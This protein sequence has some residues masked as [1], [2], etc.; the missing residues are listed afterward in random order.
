MKSNLIKILSFGACA[1]AACAPTSTDPQS[2]K[3]EQLIAQMTI[4]EKLGQM[5]LISDPYV[6]TGATVEVDPATKDLDELVRTGKVGNFLN[7]TG[8]AAT[9]RLQK[10]AVEESRLGIPLLFGFDVI[11]GYKT[12]FPIPLADAAS[13][14]MEAV[15]LSA[16][17]STIEAAANG[18]NWTYAP[19]VDISLDP[20]WGRVMEGAGEDVYLT[21]QV[22]LARIKGIQGSSLEDENTIAACAKHFVGYGAAEGGRDYATIELSERT[23]RNVYFPPFK[24]AADAGVASFMSAFN[25]V[26]GVPAS[27]NKWLLTDVLRG[28]WGY[29]GFMVSD[30]DSVQETIAHGT[31]S[32]DKH[33]ALNGIRAGV[34]M[35]MASEVYINHG[36]ELLAEGKINEEQLDEAVRRVLKIKFDLGLFDD[37]YKYSNVDREQSQT[38]TKEAHDASRD[39]ARKSIVLLKNEKNTLPISKSI[40]RIAVIGPLADDKDA[41]LGNWRGHATSNTAVSLLEGVRAAVGRDVEVV[42]AQG[43]RLVNNDDMHFFTPLEINTSDRSGFAEAVRVAKSAD[44]VIMAVGETAFMSGECRSYTDIELK[45]LQVELMGEIEK[46]GK[47]TVMALFT[48]RPLVLTEVVDMPEAILNCWL[49]GSEAGHAIAD[50]LFGDYNPSAKLPMTFPYHAGQVPIY[51]SQLNGGR[52]Y[53]PEQWGFSSKYRDAPNTPLYAF[54][55]GLSYTTFDYSNLALSSSQISMNGELRVSFD[56][57]NSGVFD[58][59]EVV[60]LYVRDMLGNQVSRPLLELKRFEKRELKRG[61]SAKFEF[62]ITAE[63]L[64]FW[65]IDNKFAAE[66]GEFTIFV[67]SSSDNLPLNARFTLTN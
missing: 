57:K 11:H 62:T 2:Q 5:N 36:A 63:D 64:A 35:D 50:V 55:Y 43:C 49:L 32:D 25:T 56:V 41:A 66:A 45:G 12:M 33:A 22:G 24:A 19:M 16:Y 54:G 48:G 46:V 44:V 20:R 61:E 40:K 31:A 53:D 60:Q 9:H 38:L 37:P 13:F 17:H 28:E 27:T 21:T 10:I 47:P 7:L 15:E 18:I 59:A 8:A 51:Y 26:Q 23:L 65:R 39:V 30:W 3:I 29:D 58:G 4:E 14:D 34:D 52:P 1:L 6:S 67:G 42:Y